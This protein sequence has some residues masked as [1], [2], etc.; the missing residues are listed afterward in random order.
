MPTP[1]E[2][3]K[4]HLM[5][6]AALVLVMTISPEGGS[7]RGT[8]DIRSLR[9]RRERDLAAHTG[10]HARPAEKTNTTSVGDCRAALAMTISLEGG[11]FLRNG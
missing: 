6:I 5:E 10:G 11:S 2:N 4:R 1:A 9:G 3:G 7:S 8:D